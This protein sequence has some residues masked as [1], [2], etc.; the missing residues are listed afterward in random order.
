MR[1]L[2]EDPAEFDQWAVNWRERLKQDS[3][4]DNVRQ[5]QMYQS[6]PIYIPRN[7]LV[8]A[9]IRAA[10]D[11]DDP[12]PFNELVTV[13]ASPYLQ[14]PGAEAYAEPPRPEQVVQQTF[15]GT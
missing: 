3:V 15:C 14:Q 2:F 9:A 11:S 8:E 12:A 6:N 5:D 10:E 1:A 7:H 13:L 4:A